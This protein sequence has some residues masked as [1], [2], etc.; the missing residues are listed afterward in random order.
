MLTRQ[1]APEK[2]R[3]VAERNVFSCV[4]CHDD[5]ATCV[6]LSK[7]FDPLPLFV[8]GSCFGGSHL[9]FD[10]ARF[11][12]SALFFDDLVNTFCLAG[13]PHLWRASSGE[14]STGVLL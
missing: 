11:V 7:T 6:R 14:L 13:F 2:F 5:I 8:H 12:M 4:I 3:V 9:C 10:P 1:V